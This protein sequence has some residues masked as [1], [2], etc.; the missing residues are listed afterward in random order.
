MNIQ[1]DF[2]A[3]KTR[4]TK[5][6]NFLSLVGKDD[7]PGAKNM[8]TESLETGMLNVN[9]RDEQGLT[10][11]EMCKSADMAR[12]LV[13]LGVNVHEKGGTG[14]TPF[15]AA[16]DTGHEEV[17]EVLKHA[18]ADSRRDRVGLTP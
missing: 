6:L 8:F 16:M 2:K 13:E 7:I 10:A 12:L 17:A 1:K 5:E 11:L 9:A 14:K 4:R 15:A 3:A 18:G